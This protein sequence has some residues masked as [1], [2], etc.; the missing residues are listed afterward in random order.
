MNK[1]IPVEKNK[2]YTINIHGLGH[3]GEGVGRYNDF[4]IFV[5]QAIPGDWIETRIIKVK[6][7]YA[8]GRLK[9]VINPSPHRVDP[10]CPIADQCGGCQIQQMDYQKQLEY[11]TQLVRDNMERIGKIEGVVIHPT[12]GMADPWNYRNKAQ[13]P[14]GWEGG[15]QLGFYAKGSHRIIETDRCLIQHPVKDRITA[16]IKNFISQ[17][18]IPVYK[19]ENHSGLLRHIVTKVGFSTNEIMVILVINGKSLPHQE[20]LIRRLTSGVEGIKSI[21]LNINRGKTNTILGGENIL[22]YGKKY[23]TDFIGNIQ[24]RISPLS[25]FQVNPVQ[26]RVLYEKALEYADLHGDELVYDAYC[27]IGTISL[28]LAQR[29]KKVIGVEVVE[30]AIEDARVNARINGIEN[31]EFYVGAAEEIIPQLYQQGKVADV[32]VVDPPRKGCDRTL[33]DTI[34]QMSP[35]RI[36]YVSCNPSTLARDLNYLEQGSYKTKEIQPVD[37]FP[38]TVHVECVT[39]MSRVKD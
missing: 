35:K 27:G 5:D 28:F 26:T 16:I 22:L 30:Q 31:V 14:L 33:L 10:P 1:E 23:I 9:R 20:D 6:N 8:I 32:V 29:A 39:L 12:I 25:F 15:V 18:Q 24:F 7:S 4:T 17:H 11:K 21:Y 3:R 2:I 37:M 13:Y 34:I 36:V 38:H 19:E